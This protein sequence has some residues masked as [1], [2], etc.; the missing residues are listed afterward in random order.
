MGATEK[1][2]DE[3]LKFSLEQ[4]DLA[5]FEFLFKRYYPQLVYFADK[6]INNIQ[7]AEDVV[8]ELFSK[9]WLKKVFCTEIGNLSSFLYRSVRNACL[10][11]LRKASRSP[12]LLQEV[13]DAL[14]VEDDIMEG[15]EV[16]ARLLQ[17]VLEH[18]ESLPSQCRRVFKLI[19]IQGKT[20]SEVAE[21]LGLSVQAVRNHKARGLSLLRSR[22]KPTHL[23]SIVLMQI[24]IMHKF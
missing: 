19:Y 5:A 2:T 6:F 4:E 7:E 17:L 22:I 1:Y 13:G 10:D 20:T 18:I 11:Y 16:F 24:E 8:M 14:S 9:L 23:L 12:L 15:E 3:Q 21:I